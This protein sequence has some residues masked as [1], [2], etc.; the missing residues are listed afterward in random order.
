MVTK[1]KKAVKV[2][3]KQVVREVREEKQFRSDEEVLK[4]ATKNQAKLLRK[5]VGG[6]NIRLLKFV[7]MSELAIGKNLVVASIRGIQP[8]KPK[9]PIEYLSIAGCNCIEVMHLVYGKKQVRVLPGKDTRNVKAGN[10]SGRRFY[11]I[12]IVPVK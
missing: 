12:Q 8:P 10:G 5:G 11:D 7:P 1:Q 3:G 9:A 4:F 2:V 6:K